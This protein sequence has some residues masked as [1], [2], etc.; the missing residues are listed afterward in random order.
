MPHKRKSFKHTKKRFNKN[1]K[2]KCN[3]CSQE[4]LDKQNKLISEKIKKA[5]IIYIQI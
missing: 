3:N 2:C 1:K 5:K 4:Y